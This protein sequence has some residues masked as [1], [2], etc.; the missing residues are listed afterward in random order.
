[1]FD[2]GAFIV[3]RFTGT[4]TGEQLIDFLFRLVQSAGTTIPASYRQLIELDNQLEVFVDDKTLQ[5]IAHINKAYGSHRGRVMTAFVTDNPQY[6]GLALMHKTL[7]GFAGIEVEVF[8]DIELACA[9]LEFEMP[10]F[11]TGIAWLEGAQSTTDNH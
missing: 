6:R 7:S 10:E 4:V 1:L 9:W 8:E 5:R 3:T 2:D 11:A